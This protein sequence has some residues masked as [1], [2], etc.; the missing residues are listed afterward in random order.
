MKRGVREERADERW[1]KRRAFT[2]VHEKTRFD[3]EQR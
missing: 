1:R 2:S 3:F